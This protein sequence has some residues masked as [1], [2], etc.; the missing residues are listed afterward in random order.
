MRNFQLKKDRN[1]K[2]FLKFMRRKE[3]LLKFM[4]KTIYYLK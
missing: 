4:F 1:V 3:I 2:L